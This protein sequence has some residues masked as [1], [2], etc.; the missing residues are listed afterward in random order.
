MLEALG[1][2]ITH[3]AENAQVD[4]YFSIHQ[5]TVSL[6]SQCPTEIGSELA[7]AHCHASQQK[8]LEGVCPGPMLVPCLGGRPWL[9]QDGLQ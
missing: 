8:R 2:N 3:D 7:E 6:P 4:G 5:A 9:G 1:G